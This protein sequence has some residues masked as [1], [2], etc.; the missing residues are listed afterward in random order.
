MLRKR[1]RSFS[2]VDVAATCLTAMV[3]LLAFMP[4]A[5]R[6]RELSKRSVCAVNLAG[7]GE[8][9]RIYAQRNDGQWMTPAFAPNVDEYGGVDYLNDDGNAG[10]YNTDA[11]EV[12]WARQW[13]TS[14]VPV[15]VAHPNTAASTT[16]AYWMLVRSGDVHVRQ[17]VC[18][19]ST[20]VWN[21]TKDAGS[22]AHPEP[23][24]TI[25]L[26]YDFEGYATISYG[27]QVPFG[28]PDTRPRQGADN[29]VIFAADKG[30]YYFAG[31]DPTNAFHSLGP[32]GRPVT[33]TDP[34]RYWRPFNS[35]N[36]GGSNNGEGQNCLYADGVVSFKRTPTVGIDHDNIYTLMLDEWDATGRNLIYGDSPHI[37]A[38]KNPYPGA[39]ALGPNP[40]DYSSTDSLIYP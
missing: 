38:V 24:S 3:L 39:E 5:A 10:F 6:L 35:P 13:P 18:P 34:P 23:R 36:H 14:S 27:Y 19:S 40:E 31:A 20:D 30:P 29:R 25:D 33:V 16:R 7:I 15:N 28:P 9:T 8:S 2:L 11:G 37:S 21:S 12:G 26:Y 17:F 4:A 1:I 32:G 22:E